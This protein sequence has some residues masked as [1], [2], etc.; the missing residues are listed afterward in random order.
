VF[1]STFGRLSSKKQTFDLTVSDPRFLDSHVV[2][3]AAAHRREIS[4]LAFRTR[5][6]IGAGLRTSIPIGYGFFAG[7]G[8]DVEYGGVVLYN[9]KADGF[10][11]PQLDDP[12]LFPS[13]V[14]RNPLSASIAWDHRDSVLLPR[15]G[16]YASLSTSYARTMF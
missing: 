11:G 2:L 14:F 9:K 5:S 16:A 13:N 7:G 12:A 15:N 6:E 4:Y 8:L 10:T 1:V 3:T